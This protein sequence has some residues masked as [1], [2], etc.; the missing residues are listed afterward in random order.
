MVHFGSVSLVSGK[1][2]DR[3]RYT[4][5]TQTDTPRTEHDT[6][7]RRNIDT[8]N[9]DVALAVRSTRIADDAFVTGTFSMVPLT[10]SARM[11]STEKGRTAAA[12]D[13]DGGE[14]GVESK[15][16]DDLGGAAAR[17]NRQRRIRR[18][19][20]LVDADDADRDVGAGSPR[21][22]T[23]PPPLTPDEMRRHF[24]PPEASFCLIDLEKRMR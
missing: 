18:Q 15:R 4:R 14:D 8:H 16:E 9:F 13:E 3:A 23:S 7:A 12:S 21:Q 1:P 20:A 19:A 22:G 6:R 17:P 11:R 10:G 2:Q 24:Q 5:E